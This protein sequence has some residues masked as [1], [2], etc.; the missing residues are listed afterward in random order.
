[1]AFLATDEMAEAIVSGRIDVLVGEP[2]EERLILS[3]FEPR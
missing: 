3:W 2:L 1:V